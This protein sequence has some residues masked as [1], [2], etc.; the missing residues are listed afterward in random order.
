MGKYFLATTNHEKAQEFLEL[1]QGTMTVMEYVVR[2]TEFA[3]FPNDYVATDMAKIKRFENEQKLSIRG[4]I[5]GLHPQDMDSMV[6]IAM[7]IE[8]EIEDARGIQD[9]GSSGKRKESQFSSSSGKKPLVQVDSRA[10]A[11]RAREKARLLVMQ[12]KWYVSVESSLDI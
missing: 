4:K 5:V 8:R 9:V 11:I 2:F 7:T 6:G 1:R 12:D 10:A 3:P